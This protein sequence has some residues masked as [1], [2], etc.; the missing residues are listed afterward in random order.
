VIFGESKLKDLYRAAVWGVGIDALNALPVTAE[1]RVFRALGRVAAVGAV[2]KRRCVEKNMR[3]AF[4]GDHGPDGRSV[5]DIAAHAF[6]SHFAN[7]Y[8]GA[9]FGR[10]DEQRWSRYLSWRGLDRLR[11]HI[12]DG[13]G[14]VLAH[15][16][17]GPAQLPTHVLGRMGVD[18]VQIGGGRVTNVSLSAM[19]EWAR[20]RRVSLESEMPVE[21]HDGARYLRPLL[22]RLC[23]GGVVMTAADGT[24]GGHEI[25]RRLFRPVLGQQMGIPVGPM[26]LAL[27][28]GAPLLTLH[29]YRD[30]GDASMYVAEVGEEIHMDRDQPILD[31]IEDGADHI[32]VWL[33]RVLQAH[34]GDWLFWDG[35]AKGALLP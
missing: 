27:Q 10:C 30:R 18:V 25:G 12:E 2:N 13:R 6:A 1:H 28:S 22:R 7:Q 23:S 35:F 8:I 15:P 9:S 11:S 17:M 14:V 20:Q 31:A 24:G 16:H 5:S 3:L 34:P 32:G 21:I 26:W 29:C 19:G 33:D 4:G